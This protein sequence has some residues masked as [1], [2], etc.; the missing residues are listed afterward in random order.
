M[1][2]NECWY[3]WRPEVLDPPGAGVLGVVNNLIE[4]LEAEFRFLVR[5]VH[6]LNC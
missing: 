3:P 2:T 5:I 6:T 1:S 4:I